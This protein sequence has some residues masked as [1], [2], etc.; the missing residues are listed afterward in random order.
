M[1]PGSDL[2]VSGTV[3]IKFSNARGRQLVNVASE[4][5]RRVQ[6]NEDVVGE[7]S[8]GFDVELNAVEEAPSAGSSSGFASIAVIM[9]MTTG[10]VGLL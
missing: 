10:F 2:T 3:L 9:A 6:N 5:V 1:T 4:H 8:F 7:G